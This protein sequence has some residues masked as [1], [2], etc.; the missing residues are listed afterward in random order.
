MVTVTSTSS[1]S[2]HSSRR[3]RRRWAPVRYVVL[4]IGALVP[5]MKALRSSL[6]RKAEDDHHG[7]LGS[8][9]QLR[10]KQNSDGFEDA[11]STAN[12]VHGIK[13]SI[14]N[15]VTLMWQ[16]DDNSDATASTTTTTVRLQLYADETPLAAAYLRYIA[17]NEEHCQKCTLYRGEPVPPNW[18]L[19]DYPDRYFDGGRWGLYAL[20]QGHC[21]CC[22]TIPSSR[23]PLPSR[24]VL[25]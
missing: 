16:L 1:S 24:T 14:S 12:G 9:H 11:R 2:S 8:I 6:W 13:D 3:P 21:C 7:V 17:T 18:G 25:P 19:E 20:V 15:I 5:V 4:T 23:Y 10:G 22:R